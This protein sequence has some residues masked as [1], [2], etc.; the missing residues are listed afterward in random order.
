MPQKGIW[1]SNP[2]LSASTNLKKGP[3][4]GPFFIIKNGGWG[5]EPSKKGGILSDTS[6]QRVYCSSIL[7]L[8]RL[9]YGLALGCERTVVDA[10]AQAIEL[11]EQPFNGIRPCT[12]LVGN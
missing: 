5:F 7:H 10:A 3:I 9:G 4:W 6:F 1:G 12:F 2:Q 11:H 8:G